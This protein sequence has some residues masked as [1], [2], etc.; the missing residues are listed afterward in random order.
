MV[1]IGTKTNIAE[2]NA[3]G[4]KKIGKKHK[5]KGENPIQQ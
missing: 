5:K 2:S 4:G 1:K 3:N